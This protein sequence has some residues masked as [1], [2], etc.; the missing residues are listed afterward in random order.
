MRPFL[1]T[2]SRAS[3]SPPAA[4]ATTFVVVEAAAGY[5]KSVLCLEQVVTGHV[6]CLGEAHD[7]V[8]GR[9]DVPVLVAADL[10]GV[11]ADAGGQLA[12]G[13]PAI[14]ADIL[15]ALTRVS[16]RSASPVALITTC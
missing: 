2:T 5:G 16:A 14:R 12:L 8:G 7:R 4:P 3:A 15:G 1:D 6:G 10:A 11:G 13:E 9:G